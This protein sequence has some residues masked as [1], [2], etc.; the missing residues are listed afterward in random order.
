MAGRTFL[1]TG[2]TKGIGR[3]ITER[4]CNR[5]DQVVGVARQ[6]PD[7]SFPGTFFA[8]DLK[9]ANQTELLFR[10]IEASQ[11]IDGVV[12]NVGWGIQQAIPDLTLD[13]LRD[14][15]NIN[16][17][18]AVLA[19]RIFSPKMTERR[20]GRIVNIASIV[21]LGAPGRSTY[22]AAK[23][24]LIAFTQSWAIELARSGI[25]VNAVA[26]GNTATEGF[27][28]HCPPGSERESVL[29]RRVPVGRLAEPADVA[30]AV[31]FFLSDEAG[32]I[33]GQTLFVDGGAS[34][35]GTL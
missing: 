32:F 7:A 14:V 9:D 18:P 20:F 16:L 25:T 15:M 6:P 33:T 28:R 27:R 11:Q 13:A 22:A 29:T 12:N 1:V 24:A 35:R 30:A 31:A 5:G 21:V 2:A 3:A 19:A 26:P 4:L 17:Q 34:V 8:G 23:S 10:H